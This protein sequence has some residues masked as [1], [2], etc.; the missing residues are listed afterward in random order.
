MQIVQ[1]LMRKCSSENVN[2]IINY[3]SS[4]N[5]KVYDCSATF[6]DCIYISKLQTNTLA[7]A[8]VFTLSRVSTLVAS[9]YKNVELVPCSLFV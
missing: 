1:L 5:F 7:G 2:K 4:R 6:N 8:R 9:L 3:Y